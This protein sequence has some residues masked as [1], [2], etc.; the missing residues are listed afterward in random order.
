MGRIQFQNKKMVSSGFTCIDLLCHI[1][2]NPM[3]R[4][5]YMKTVILLA[6]SF[7]GLF[8]VFCPTHALIS[9]VEEI[10]YSR[11]LIHFVMASDTLA[12]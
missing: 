7:R 1:L 12:K 3:F 8:S 4:P 10:W 11:Q 2:T 5:K 9:P 6:G